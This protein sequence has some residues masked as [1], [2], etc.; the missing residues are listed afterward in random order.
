MKPVSV[1]GGGAAQHVPNATCGA[2]FFWTV[3]KRRRG[4]NPGL[5]SDISQNTPASANNG[6]QGHKCSGLAGHKAAS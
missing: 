4:A 5:R 2:A 1:D 6:P 3:S